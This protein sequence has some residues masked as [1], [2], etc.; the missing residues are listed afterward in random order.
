MKTKLNIDLMNWYLKLPRP[1]LLT[2]M[3]TL[4][5]LLCT[6]NLLKYFHNQCHYMFIVCVKS[7]LNKRL[8][9]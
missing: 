9:K 8:A 5:L 2:K 7:K 1:S 4:L 6:L 3:I